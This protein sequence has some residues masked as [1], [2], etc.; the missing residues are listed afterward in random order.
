MGL[1]N[2]EA[3]LEKKK[4]HWENFGDSIDVAFLALAHKVNIQTEKDTLE[5]HTVI[6]YESINQY[7]AIF[8]KEQDMICTVKGSLEKIISFSKTMQVGEN[9]VPIDKEKLLKQNE[10]LA[11]NGYRMIAIAKGIIKIKKEEYEEE[12]IKDLT[13]LGF[14]AFIDPIRKDALA[15]VETCK[16]AGIEV[17]MITGDHPLTA[18]A[19]AKE[20]QIVDNYDKVASGTVIEEMLKKGT[21]HFDTF[22]KDKKVFT[23]VTPIQK[24]EIVESYKRQG[25]FVAVTGDGVNDAP[26]LKAA[27]IGIAMGSGTDVA[28]ETSTMIITDDKFM[29]IVSGI[30]EGRKAYNNVRKVIYYLLSNGIAEV[31]FFLAAIIFNYPVPLVAVQL[32]WLNLVTDG[33]QDAALAFEKGTRNVMQEKP[34]NPNEKIFNK[35]L[36]QETLLSGIMIG[37][38]VFAFWIYL[39]EVKALP[40]DTANSNTFLAS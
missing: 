11:S 39:I 40:T 16:K 26:A 27:N 32:L 31:I 4:H 13:L 8:Y 7:S 10:S 21:K 25:E 6:P 38:I 23:R 2:N 36:T 37:V 5:I 12:D 1:F 35:L 30:E 34:R 14:V 17:V 28:K 22:I 9:K 24:L 19:I 18:Y 29:S 33:L 15:A 20:L 3:H